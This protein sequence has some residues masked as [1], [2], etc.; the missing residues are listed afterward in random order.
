MSVIW[1]QCH[2]NTSDKLL[3]CY[4]TWSCDV[5]NYLKQVFM[6]SLSQIIIR[7]SKV[8][9]CLIFLTIMAE[10]QII[11]GGV[12]EYPKIRRQ[13]LHGRVQDVSK[14]SQHSSKFQTPIYRNY[15]AL[16]V[17]SVK[18]SLGTADCE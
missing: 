15:S 14:Q 12:C 6:L 10:I 8:Q 3:A 5:L 4:I 9:Y 1:K 2:R 17:I 16:H 11:Y 7:L 13:C 18:C